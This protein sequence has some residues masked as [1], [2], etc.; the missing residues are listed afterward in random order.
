[1]VVLKGG[2]TIAAKEKYRIEKGRAIITLPNGTQ[3][4][5]PADQ[6]DVARTEEMNRAG[7]GTAVVLPLPRAWPTS[8]RR[9]IG[10]ARSTCGSSRSSMMSPERSTGLSIVS[11]ISST[12]TRATP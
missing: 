8:R 6:I 7:Y 9:V 10:L 1:M 4:F 12:S 5:V 2:K 11:P 3:T